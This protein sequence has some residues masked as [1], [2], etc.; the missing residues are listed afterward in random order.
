MKT[1]STTSH[2]ADWLIP[3]GLLA[4]AFIPI[5]AGGVRLTVLTGG[6]L[7]TPENARFVTS[8]IPVIVHIVSVT[9]Y[10]LLGAFQFSPGFRRRWPAWHRRAG[11]SLVGAGLA[12]A[13][14]GLWMA[15]FY[16]IVPADSLLLHVFRLLFGTAMGSRS[17]WGLRRSGSAT[18]VRIRTGCAAPTPSASARERRP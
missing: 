5:V 9:I 16:A 8:P 12:A 4:L 3:A 10:A 13:L 18:S 7:I 1:G 6:P 17:Y 15:N 2:S 11:R 14:S